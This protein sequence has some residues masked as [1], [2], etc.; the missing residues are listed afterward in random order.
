MSADDDILKN[1]P[2]LLTP[3]V[4]AYERRLR[5]YGD[6]PRGVFWKNA[7]WQRKRYEILTGIFD[8][9]AMAGGLT[10]HDFGC[11]YGALFDFLADHPAMH[12]SRYI[13][14]DMSQ[15]MIDSA[16]ARIDDPRAQFQRQVRATV[17]A[18]YTFVSGTFNM[19]IDADPDDWDSYV[20]AS[21]RQLWASTR[22][23]LAF[24]MLSLSARERFD[25]LY[26]VAPEDYLEF[27]RLHLD[28]DAQLI[29]QPPLPDFTIFV[30]RR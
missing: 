4:L 28:P 7:E 6:T 14:T 27:A 3:V 17:S 1:S 11:G 21:L 26:Y 29:V 15:A 25:G 19:H 30:R 8:D 23:G 22:K 16:R 12:M 13:G 5:H 24:N 2:K 9:V 20:K 10:I 18:D